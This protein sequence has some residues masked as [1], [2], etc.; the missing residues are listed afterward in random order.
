LK[1][2]FRRAKE[3]GFDYAL[4][5]DADGQHYPA[6]IPA[7]LAALA[8]HTGALVVGS[9]DLAAD[10]MPEGNTFANRFSNFWF[11]VE[12]GQ[13]LPDTQTG[14]RVYPL[15]RLSGWRLMSSRYEAEFALL[16]FAAW[17]GVELVPVNVRVY[18]PPAEERVSHF[19]PYA[20]FA[21]ISAMNTLLCFGAVV[22]G[23]PRRFFRLFRKKKV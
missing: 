4:T 17:A 14:L 5:I 2:G 19:R 22:Y 8:T 18:Y 15:Q 13:S 6:D 23:Y 1:Q 10:N 7:L 21:R 12:T 11:K 20:D 9:R 3:R 16:V